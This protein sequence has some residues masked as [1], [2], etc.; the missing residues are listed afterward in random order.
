MVV[1]GTILTGVPSRRE[2]I[3]T[4]YFSR[5]SKHSVHPCPRY[6]YLDIQQN[7][8]H[9]SIHSV[10]HHFYPDN[11]VFLQFVFL[12]EIIHIWMQDGAAGGETAIR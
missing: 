9:L 11:R 10:A 7:D 8:Y 3:I 1:L 2:L 12:Y 4:F 6:E 5:I